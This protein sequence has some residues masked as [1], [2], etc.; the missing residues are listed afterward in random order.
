MGTRGGPKSW[1]FFGSEKPLLTEK[2]DPLQR[3]PTSPRGPWVS[4]STLSLVHVPKRPNMGVQKGSSCV[5]R[6]FESPF[7]GIRSLRSVRTNGL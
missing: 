2:Q 6:M 4:I 7:L 3:E 5:T 1:V